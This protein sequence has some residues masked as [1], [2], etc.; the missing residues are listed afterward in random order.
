MVFASEL[1]SVSGEHHC[2]SGGLAAQGDDGGPAV[3]LVETKRSAA[4][5]KRSEMFH[6]DGQSPGTDLTLWFVPVDRGE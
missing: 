5:T 6:F 4:F 1:A 3:H 2:P